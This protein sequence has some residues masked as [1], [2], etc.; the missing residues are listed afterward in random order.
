MRNLSL[1]A[2]AL[3]LI[4][5]CTPR[6]NDPT[7]IDPEKL[8]GLTKQERCIFYQTALVAALEISDDDARKRR[9]EKLYEPLITVYCVLPEN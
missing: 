9:I 3:A 1:C 6:E 5:S 8:T 4:V 7:P 2:A